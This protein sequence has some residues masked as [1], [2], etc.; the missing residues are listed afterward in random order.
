MPPI[1]ALLNFRRINVLA[2]AN[3][4]RNTANHFKKTYRKSV[5]NYTIK[6]PLE[7]TIIKSDDDIIIKRKQI[8]LVILRID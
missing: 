1:Y 7:L 5:I 6:L 3:Q 8:S 4:I 2:V